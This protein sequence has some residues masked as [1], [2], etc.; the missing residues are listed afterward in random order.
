MTTYGRLSQTQLAFT[1][2]GIETSKF[3]QLDSP[4]LELSKNDGTN[5]ANIKGTSLNTLTLS[6][7]GDSGNV[8]LTGI[9]TP[10]VVTS[11][12]GA[13][14]NNMTAVTLEKTFGVRSAHIS[15]GTIDNAVTTFNADFM[16]ASYAA[17]TTNTLST[18]ITTN[19]S[20]Y[21]A[22]PFQNNDVAGGTPSLFTITKQYGFYCENYNSGN[23]VPIVYGS[24]AATKVS[25]VMTN[26]WQLY[27]S[28]TSLTT[29]G[30]YIGNRLGIGF[31]VEP[32]LNSEVTALLHIGPGTT[33][34]AQ[35]RLAVVTAAPA[36]PNS[37]DIWLESDTNTGL[38]IRINGVT[39]TFTVT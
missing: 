8:T 29:V 9:Y 10:K 27:M 21:S 3:V 20:Y 13:V 4:F 26:A 23:K 32:A 16:S 12:Y 36:N 18:A 15:T 2:N 28:G 25:A 35:I 22:I 31:A 6:G 38:K 17:K 37:G 30:S 1:Q 24:G 33:G 19:Y 11:L 5:L 7:T 14:S 34:S 39:K